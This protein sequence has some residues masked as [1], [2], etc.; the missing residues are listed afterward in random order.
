MSVYWL[1]HQNLVK[2]YFQNSCITLI[3][4][5]AVSYHMRVVI[6]LPSERWRGV[7]NE[8]GE[9]GVLY[10]CTVLCCRLPLG[11][12]LRD[13]HYCTSRKTSHLFWSTVLTVQYS[14]VVVL[15]FSA[16]VQSLH[17]PE[18]N[19]KHHWNST[20]MN[21]KN[22]QYSIQYT[23]QNETR[24]CGHTQP[25]AKSCKQGESRLCLCNGLRI[26]M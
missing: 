11:K 10:I 3:F 5:S 26:N 8:G 20:L 19:F 2:K 16:T 23:C 25:E 13:K 9:R 21:F 22:V 7:V 17:F 14:K 15:I 12:E 6:P 4:I 1:P 24:C 18:K